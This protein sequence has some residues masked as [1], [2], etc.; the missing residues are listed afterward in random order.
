MP[1]LNL[2][3]TY[4]KYPEYKDSGIEWLKKIPSGWN[5][6]PVRAVLKERNE[7]NSKLEIDNILS[8]MKGVGVI[9]YADKG[10]VGN[11]SSDRP[12]AYKIVRSGDIVLNSMNLSIGSVGIAREEGVTSSVYIIYGPRPA[13]SNTDFYHY[14]FETTQFQRHLA[15]YGKGIM[16]L[17]EAVRE[18]NIRNQEVIAP[19][20]DTQKIISDFLDKKIKII[21]QIIKKKQ[22]LISLLQEKRSALITHAV[23]KGLDP[24]AKMKPSGIDWID[25]IPSNWTLNKMK[26]LGEVIIG[27]TYSPEDVTNEEGTLVLRSSNIKDGHILL[28]DNVYVTKE[29]PKKLI[30]KI[31]DVLICSRNGS[32]KLVGKCA[33]IEKDGLNVTFGAFMTIFRS[34]FGKYIS[35]FLESNLFLSQLTTVSTSTINQL[36]TEYLNNVLIPTPPVNEQIEIIKAIETKTKQID[37][38]I[39]DV[40]TQIKHLQEY[41]LSLIYHAVT[42]KIKI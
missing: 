4:Q 25:T 26:Y 15:S 23:T 28:N 40:D 32:A 21:D 34:K 2:K 16:E 9:R 12:E 6:L 27:L 17:R 18:I 39:S 10:D 33:Y 36:T 31:G 20:L 14:L 42:G 5:L 37:K 8:V 13:V 19:S 3:K 38:I 22:K 41:R 7:K 11:K 30:T 24:K 1:V 29:I 35:S